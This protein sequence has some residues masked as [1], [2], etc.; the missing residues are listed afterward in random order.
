MGL[1][2]GAG[3]GLIVGYSTRYR[4]YPTEITY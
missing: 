1:A 3:G 4:A 2:G